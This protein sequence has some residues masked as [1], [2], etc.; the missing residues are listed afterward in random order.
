MNF[1]DKLFIGSYAFFRKRG[2]EDARFA[3]VATTC[4]VQF[5]TLIMPLLLFK[6]LLRSTFLSSFHTSNALLFLPIPFIWIGV[7]YFFYS[8]E[9][10]EKLYIAFNDMTARN[11]QKWTYLHLGLLIFWC[12]FLFFLVYLNK[13]ILN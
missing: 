1:T 5:C 10:I 7:I 9:K 2:R 3:A 12:I 11:K 6:I 4:A 13:H 8:K